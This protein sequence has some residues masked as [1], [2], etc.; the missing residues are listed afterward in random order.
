MKSKLSNVMQLWQAPLPQSSHVPLV[1]SPQLAQ[2]LSVSHFIL[3]E[4]KV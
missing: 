3:E 4:P 1:A 2:L